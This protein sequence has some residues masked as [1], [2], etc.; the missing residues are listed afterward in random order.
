[1]ALVPAASQCRAGPIMRALFLRAG[2][3]FGTLSASQD[4]EETDASHP[5]FPRPRPLSVDTSRPPD[6]LLPRR[7]LHLVPPRRVLRPL[8]NAD[9]HFRNPAPR[10]RDPPH[11]HRPRL[12]QRRPPALQ[13]RP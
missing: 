6:H 9:L 4:L 1:M 8:L 2:Q 11:H 3:T 13:G 12:L 7:L 5:P 10:D